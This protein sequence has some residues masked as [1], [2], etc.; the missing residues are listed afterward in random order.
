MLHIPVIA[1]PG[2]RHIAVGVGEIP[3]ASSGAGVIAWSRGSEHTVHGQKSSANIVDAD[4][5]A[6]AQLLHLYFIGTKRFGG[7]SHR[8]VLRMIEIKNVIDVGTKLRRE[9]L[10]G[11]GRVFG[12]C[13][14]VEPGPVRVRERSAP[15]GCFG[16][17]I[18]R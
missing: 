3:L 8:V 2:L 13:V 1:A 17:K 5:A 16:R 11:H 9:V 10:G 12:A 18:W 15:G 7:A 4:V 6:K 14:A